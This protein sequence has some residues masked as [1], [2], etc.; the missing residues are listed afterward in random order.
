MFRKLISALLGCTLMVSVAGCAQ[1]TAGIN[2]V[3][4][5]LSSPAADQAAHNLEVGA[6]AFV[7]NVSSIAKLA[8]LVETGIANGNIA[9]IDPKS[10]L[11]ATYDITNTVIVVSEDVCTS[12][13]GTVG[14]QAQV[15]SLSNG[16]AV[17]TAV[18]PTK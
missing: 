6:M 17:A 3:T 10:S 15:S 16:V 7:C 12:L 2:S 18:G 4:G 5:A 9:T 11:A 1:V 8:S 13:Q 14:A